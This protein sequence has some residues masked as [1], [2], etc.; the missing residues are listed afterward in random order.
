[1]TLREDT[2]F[3]V[4]EITYSPDY[5]PDKHDVDDYSDGKLLREMAIVR[6]DERSVLIYRIGI[7]G[8]Q[9]FCAFLDTGTDG[10]TEI[11]VTHTNLSFMVDDCIN[12][13]INLKDSNVIPL[14]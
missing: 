9:W 8:F 5:S 3:D 6:V 14:W 7:P 13:L 10:G 2:L 11:P 1:M 4:V 12:Y